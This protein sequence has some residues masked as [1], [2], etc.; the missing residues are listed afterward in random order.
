MEGEENLLESPDLTFVLGDTTS[1]CSALPDESFSLIHSDLPF[2]TGRVQ[3]GNAGQYE[4]KFED[5]GAWLTEQVTLYR[6]L[7]APK[8][9]LALQLDDIFYDK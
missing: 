2:N 6:R 9:V 4:D 7:L 1:V 3:K 8:G 5:F